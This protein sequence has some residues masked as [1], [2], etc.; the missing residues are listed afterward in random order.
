MDAHTGLKWR[1]SC[2]PRCGQLSAESVITIADEVDHDVKPP[3]RLDAG[4][5]SR[6][7]NAKSG[8]TNCDPHYFQ[9]HTIWPTDCHSDYEES[10]ASRDLPLN[11][12]ARDDP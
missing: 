9:V 11:N 8:R 2:V 12:R 3:L 7:Q 6:H 4:Q 5:T 1:L 10:C